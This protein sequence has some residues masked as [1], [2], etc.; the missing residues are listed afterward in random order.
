MLSI[1]LNVHGRR[2]TGR[3]DFFI[4]IGAIW[5]Y[6]PPAGS[7]DTASADHKFDASRVC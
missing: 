6:R 2:P 4:S 1:S 5:G 3:D 7:L